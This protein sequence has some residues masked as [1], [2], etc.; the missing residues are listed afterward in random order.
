M[1]A[2]LRDVTRAWGRGRRQ[3][4]DIPKA[5]PAFLWQAP[6]ATSAR[7]TRD[8]APPCIFPPRA[9][10][11]PSTSSLAGSFACEEHAYFKTAA[12]CLTWAVFIK[13][14]TRYMS[15]PWSGFTSDAI[16]VRRAHI[17]G[18]DAVAGRQSSP[19][20]HGRRRTSSG[21]SSGGHPRRG[22]T[23]DILVEEHPRKTSPGP[24]NGP[25]GRG[26][27]H[28]CHLGRAL[29]LGQTLG[30]ILFLGQ[31]HLHVRKRRLP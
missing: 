18:R 14:F 12:G 26:G 23:K 7:P 11:R 30:V 15:L 17:S 5:T 24:P 28:G 1:N 29:G 2:G 4:N 6:N 10:T 3:S 19:D 13:S 22:A 21:V 9:R 31:L 27:F 8:V 20:L 16:L 25:R